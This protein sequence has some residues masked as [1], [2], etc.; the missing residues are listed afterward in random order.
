MKKKFGDLPEEGKE[1]YPLQDVTAKAGGHVADNRTREGADNKARRSAIIQ[2]QLH[3]QLIFA[4]AGAQVVRPALYGLNFF[5]VSKLHWNIFAAVN[6]ITILY[7]SGPAGAALAALRP[8][9]P[10]LTGQAANAYIQQNYI[11]QPIN[12]EAAGDTLWCVVNLPCTIS[13]VVIGWESPEQ[14]PVDLPIR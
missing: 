11:R 10:W 13:G 8:I 1:L 5:H 14:Y 6:P 7:A 12:A 4:A 3:Y 2:F 9:T